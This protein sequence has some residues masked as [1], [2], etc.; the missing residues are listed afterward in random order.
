MPSYYWSYTTLA[1]SPFSW[2]VDF[3]VGRADIQYKSSHY[4]VRAVRGEQSGSFG[5]YR[6][7][8]DGTVTDTDTGLMWQQE[9]APQ[10]YTWQEAL[11][12][13]ESLLLAGYEDWRLPSVN[14]LQSLVDY[15]RYD[16]A[17]DP[18]FVYH[19]IDRLYWSSTT[20]IR[21][22]SGAGAR[23]VDFCDGTS[24]SGGYKSSSDYFVR[25]VRGG[26]CGSFYD[27]D[28]DTIPDENDNC[29]HVANPNQED[30][31]PSLGNGIGDACECEAD[32]MCDDDVDGSDASMFK[33]HFGR[34][35]SHY[36]C[37]TLDPCH[38]DFS[39]DGDVDGTDAS[40]F[41]S[42]FGR[43]SIQNPCPVCVAGVAWC[44]Y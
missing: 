15:S 35:I 11:N 38:G 12:Y 14:E 18:V 39:C 21:N 2:I 3:S 10:S 37:T 41:K 30:T 25:A 28:C 4:S 33:Y 6:D 31:Y 42:D 43:S 32:F 16:P 5:N 44:T 17:I 27:L 8:G 9:M 36:P 40:L 19:N 23:V 22:S 1:H 29:L 7:N 34:S 24:Y 13:C 20:D 26:Q